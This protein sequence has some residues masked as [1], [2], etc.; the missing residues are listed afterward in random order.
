M[1]IYDENFSKYHRINLKNTVEV[2]IR[3]IFLG[4]EMFTIGRFFLLLFLFFYFL[5]SFPPG[6]SKSVCACR[7][8]APLP[9]CLQCL[10]GRGASLSRE[11]VEVLLA[12]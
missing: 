1:R 2:K 3:Q 12:Q 5:M 7:S 11:L 6:S 9:V 8:H 10:A 4:P